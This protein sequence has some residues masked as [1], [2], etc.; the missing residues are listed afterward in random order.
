M[1]KYLVYEQI[2]KQ[3]QIGVGGFEVFFTFLPNSL[4]TSGQRVKDLAYN[5]NVY[6]QKEKN[7]AP[8]IF[9]IFRS[10]LDW[11]QN[12]MPG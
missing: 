8:V 7:I 2:K 10:I 3:L 5:P 11:A 12:I 9:Y 1:S 4:S 6:G